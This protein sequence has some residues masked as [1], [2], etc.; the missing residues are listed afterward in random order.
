LG[1]LPATNSA[2]GLMPIFSNNVWFN[3]LTGAIAGYFGFVVNEP[4]SSTNRI[5]V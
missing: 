3:A 5:N 1:L 4:V 2:F